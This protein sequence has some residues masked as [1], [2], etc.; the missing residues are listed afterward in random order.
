MSGQSMRL[1]DRA[2]LTRSWCLL[3]SGAII[4]LNEHVLMLLRIYLNQFKA[5]MG[6]LDHT[7]QITRSMY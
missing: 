5:N 4:L 7:L 2:R 3:L 6:Q 1:D